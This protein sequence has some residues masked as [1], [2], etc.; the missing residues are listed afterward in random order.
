[1]GPRLKAEDDPSG[2]VLRRR[3]IVPRTCSSSPRINH[4]G[5][6]R[7]HYWA[8]PLAIVIL[9]FKPRTHFSAGLCHSRQRAGTSRLARPVSTGRVCA[10][11][12][13]GPRP[14]A[15]DDTSGAIHRRRLIMLCTR[16]SS[17]PTSHSGP[18]P[19]SPRSVSPAIVILGL[20]PRTHFSA[21]FVACGS[22]QERAAWYGLFN[23]TRLGPAPGS[24][25]YLYLTPYRSR[26]AIRCPAS[27]KSPC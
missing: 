21:V 22:A 13:M 11:F 3:L 20:V 8:V 7:A 9:G 17:R 16:S 14:K 4:P 19:R 24:H 18:C 1:M 23:R 12:T 5:P 25:F 6:D 2:A 15:E 10:R 26:R 27:I